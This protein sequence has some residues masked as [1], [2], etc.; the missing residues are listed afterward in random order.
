MN[1][2]HRELKADL[3]ESSLENAVRLAD[4]KYSQVHAFIGEH[5]KDRD[6]ASQLSRHL[7]HSLRQGGGVSDDESRIH[8][9]VQTAIEDVK[10]LGRLSRKHN[11]HHHYECRFATDF[12]ELNRS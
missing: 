8:P 10:E 3:D 7:L 2:E 4:Q 1:C 9:D 5:L 12:P 11:L 6:F